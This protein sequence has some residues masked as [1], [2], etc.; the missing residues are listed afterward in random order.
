MAEVPY[1]KL[2]NPN[3]EDEGQDSEDS[4]GMDT[5]GSEDNGDGK[6]ETPEWL[7]KTG[8]FALNAG[9]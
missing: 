1:I 7:K 6:K 5:N 9:M 3:P 2:N 4:S 8:E